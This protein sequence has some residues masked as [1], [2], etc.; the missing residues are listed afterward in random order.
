[1]LC[2]T[3]SDCAGISNKAGGT[4]REEVHHFSIVI[5]SE[6]EDEHLDEF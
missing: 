1:M 4:T 5:D 2:I 3:L 6:N